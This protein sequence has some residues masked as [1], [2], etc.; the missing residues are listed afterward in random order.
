LR[1]PTNFT[2]TS[3]R[4]KDHRVDVIKVSP[5]ITT[6]HRRHSFLHD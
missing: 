3:T 5:S 2:P 6:R 1:Q 4:H